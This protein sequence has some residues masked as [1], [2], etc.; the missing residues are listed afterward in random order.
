MRCDLHIKVDSDHANATRLALIRLQVRT[1]A[2]DVKMLA[3]DA[4]RPKCATKRLCRRAACQ[5]CT[6]SRRRRYS[7]HLARFQFNECAG[8]GTLI[9]WHGHLAFLQPH[10]FVLI[11]RTNRWR[12]FMNAWRRGTRRC[13]PPETNR[14]RAQALWLQE[15]N[16]RL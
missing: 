5:I 11:Y 9:F 10:P 15:L 14:F 8:A 13:K 6:G 4:H 2:R 16:A 1:L 7:R 3:L 12:I